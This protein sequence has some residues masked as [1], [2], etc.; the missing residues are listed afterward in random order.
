MEG[1]QHLQYSGLSSGFTLIVKIP[2]Y[3]VLGKM[4]I[5]SQ[6]HEF[7]LTDLPLACDE[8]AGWNVSQGCVMMLSTHCYCTA[9]SAR[10]A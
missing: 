4:S 5:K 7:S 6:S 10:V 2:G 3:A 9:S 1:Q 8:D